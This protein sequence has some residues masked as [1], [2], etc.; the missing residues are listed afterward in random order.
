MGLGWSEWAGIVW[1]H[2]ASLGFPVMGCLFARISLG[3]T[4][5]VSFMFFYLNSLKTELAQGDTCKVL[6]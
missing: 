4:S 3:L 1:P 2:S 5:S 6:D